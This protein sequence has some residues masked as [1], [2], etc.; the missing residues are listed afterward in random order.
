M[1]SV[2][3]KQ[4]VLP[5]MFAL[6]SSL[7][8]LISLALIVYG[9]IFVKRYPHSFVSNTYEERTLFCKHEPG[10]PDESHVSLRHVNVSDSETLPPP[11]PEPAPM[12]FGLGRPPDR[13]PGV[14]HQQRQQSQQM[15]PLPPGIAGIARPAGYSPTE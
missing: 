11:T 1:I 10:N 9:L 14:A 13:P 3:L 5:Q 6:F 12:S 15:P 7:G 8:G 2:T 4:G